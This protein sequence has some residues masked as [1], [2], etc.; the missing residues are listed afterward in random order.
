MR[1]VVLGAGFGGL[2]LTTRLSDELG[3]DA[4]VVLIDKSDGFVFG[5]SKLDV[6][7]GRATA[8]AVHHS[9]ANLTRP[10]VEFVKATVSRID[11]GAKRVE[12]D[13]GTFDADIIVVA[14]G[15]DLDPGATPG[16]IE[17]GHEFYT[18]PGAF[19]L[20]DVIANFDGGRV[21]VAVTSTPFKCPPAPSETAL[22]MHDFLTE[23]GLRDRSEIALVTPLP[24]P[25]PPSPPASKALLTAFAERAI[26]WHPEQL[27][28]A[29]D[30]DRK[31][32]QFADGDEMPY[33]LFLGV[34]RHV[35]PPVVVDAGLTV[36]GWI[37]V[38]PSTL[39]TAF[40][41]VYAVGDVANVG[42]PKA[43]V[44]AEGQASVVAERILARVRGDGEASEYDGRGVCYLEFGNEQVA[45]VAVTFRPGQPPVGELEGPSPSY[46]ADKVA[47][48]STRIT[49]WFGQSSPASA[50][51][52]P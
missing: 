39:E 15:A 50:A 4:D 7:F 42:T 33:D 10:G 37:P 48:G 8:D 11:P 13:A 25:I 32:A 29:L 35:A 14:L 27:I 30:P 9:Y 31:V 26:E 40:P 17:G 6:M 1:V 43:G 44:F 38:D 41:D 3:D 5:F 21:V 52:S 2:E 34:P 47:F 24:A 36:E 22:L 12:T 46:V 18:E 20:R 45:K 16:L 51:S 19:A 23:R 49:R 28:R